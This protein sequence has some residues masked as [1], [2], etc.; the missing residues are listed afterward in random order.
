[1]IRDGMNSPDLSAPIG[2][3]SHV[4]KS[5]DLLFLS[6]QVGDDPATGKFAGDDVASQATQIFANLQT[7]LRVAGADLSNVLRVAVYL[8]DMGDFAAMNAVYATHFSAPFPARTTVAVAALP[9]GA[10]VEMDVIA[11]LG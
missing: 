4:V 9:G 8:T 3:F 5:G 1:M 7:V 10:R 2:P 6:G 11:R